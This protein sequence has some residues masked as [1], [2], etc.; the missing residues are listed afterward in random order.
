M[1]LS[2]CVTSTTTHMTAH[3]V[4]QQH[5]LKKSFKETKLN[6]EKIQSPLQI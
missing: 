5:V 3:S 6:E 4:L 2:S 1:G